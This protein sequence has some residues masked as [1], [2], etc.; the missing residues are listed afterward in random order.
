MTTP[1][2]PSVGRTFSLTDFI[3]EIPRRL[4]QLVKKTWR[5]V[6]GVFTSCFKTTGALLTNRDIQW[7]RTERR[8]LRAF[9]IGNV[10]PV[11]PRQPSTEKVPVETPPINESAPIEPSPA[12]TAFD[13][14]LEELRSFARDV[15]TLSVDEAYKQHFAQ[16]VDKLQSS[17]PS[18][19]PVI[20]SLTK[21]FVEMGDK[22]AKPLYRKFA[23]QKQELIDP[24]LRKV[25]KTL[26]RPDPLLPPEEHELA[27][28]EL[29]RELLQQ[30]REEFKDEGISFF[31]RLDRDYI[32]PIL[33]WLLFSDQSRPLSE[34]FIPAKRFQEELIDKVFERVISLL[35]EKK[36]DHFA[37]LLERTIQSRLSDITQNMLKINAQRIADHIS[38]RVAALIDT[39][40]FT[41]MFDNVVQKDL[42]EHIQGV[43]A[44]ERSVASWK[45]RLE[46]SKLTALSEPKKPTEVALKEE[47]LRYLETVEQHGS[48]SLY[49]EHKRLKAYAN[50]PFC[51]PAMKELIEQTI[52]LALQEK[53]PEQFRRANEK[54][55][56]ETLAERLLDLIMPSKKVLNA[57]NEPVETDPFI[58]LW[59]ILHFP[60]EFNEL[61]HH[62]EELTSEFITPDTMA[63][64]GHVKQPVIEIVKNI[65][66]NTTKDLLRKHLAVFVKKGIETVIQ[67][68]SLNNITANATLPTLNKKL[69]AA[70]AKQEVAR[71]PK[72]F[73][74]IATAMALAPQE[75]KQQQKEV[76][77]HTLMSHMIG[78]FTQF[79]PENF[80]PA[81]SADAPE[82]IEGKA[83]Q[84]EDWIQILLP[85]VNDVEVQLC[86][87][88]T[89][90]TSAPGPKE[91]E[92]KFHTLFKEQE[93]ANN[94][95]IGNIVMDLIFRVGEM[96]SEWVVDW[97]VKDNI[98]AS[99]TAMLEPWRVSH[100]QIIH[101]MTDALR[102]K[103]LATDE[104][105]RIIAGEPD[106]PATLVDEKL[107]HQIDVTSRLAHDMI[108]AIAQQK[109]TI[110]HYAVKKL[111]GKDHAFMNSQISLI[112]QRVLGSRLAN[113]NLILRY[114]ESLFAAL[115]T[116]SETIRL[117]DNI[118]VQQIA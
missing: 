86:A 112:Y 7:L 38:E 23:E 99:T 69:I 104:I 96:K 107:A 73:L 3:K 28:E 68:E 76:L 77:F 43:A 24:T 105:R 13:P 5:A 33:T 20:K 60:E 118:K 63:L 116:A 98:S 12:Y 44:A 40:P 15:A 91:I 89:P 92:T 55:I 113:E 22:A 48:E 82:K 34:S 64:L 57:D 80:I 51:M 9:Q 115:G 114:C 102:N 4:L 103:F 83:L 66:R 17:A 81:D 21:L 6:S 87:A 111:L 42:R 110:T 95:E 72:I 2:N 97:F 19:P 85:I 52:D 88:M 30:I 106:K 49:L 61:L 67:P 10:Q 78:K 18:I 8:P 36:I 47:A 50:H 74:P 94:P 56:Y 11:P 117:R 16:K 101:A 14:A 109:G 54:A 75:Q 93:I 59:D 25:F 58:E 46:K 79:N 90:E 31:Q 35:V 108:T 29:Y 65:F 84:A 32:E 100:E 26:I 70:F 27:K 45:E 37:K 1:V 71:N 53:D 41:Q 62:T 39:A